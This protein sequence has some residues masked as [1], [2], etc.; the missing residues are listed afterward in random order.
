MEI[1]RAAVI[2]DLDYGESRLPSDVIV[3]FGKLIIFTLRFNLLRL[4]G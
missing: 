2:A 4:F 3:F 1:Y